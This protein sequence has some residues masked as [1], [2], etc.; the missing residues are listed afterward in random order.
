[1]LGSA[2]PGQVLAC[3]GTLRS[4]KAQQRLKGAL[5][6]SMPGHLGHCVL[7]PAGRV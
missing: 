1:M 5:I 7:K 4:P 3:L 2:E 6:S